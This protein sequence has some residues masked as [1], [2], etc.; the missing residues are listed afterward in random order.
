MFVEKYQTYFNCLHVFIQSSY[1]K[2]FYVL[3]RIKYIVSENWKGSCQLLNINHIPGRFD[4][5][6]RPL[7]SVKR[8]TKHFLTDF[9]FRNKIIKT[10]RQIRKILPY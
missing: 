5:K 10:L 3:G 9:I 2:I 7:S 8:Q 6:I 1:Y 4:A